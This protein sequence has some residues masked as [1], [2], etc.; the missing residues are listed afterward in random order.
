MNTDLLKFWG[1]S[2]ISLIFSL[3]LLKSSA[4]N[5]QFFTFPFQDKAAKSYLIERINA[6]NLFLRILRSQDTEKFQWLLE[7]LKIKYIP[8]RSALEKRKLSKRA[9]RKKVARDSM[10]QDKKDKLQELR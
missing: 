10:L 5:L 7:E 1:L 6:R 4:K 2:H 3:S 9:L 8:L